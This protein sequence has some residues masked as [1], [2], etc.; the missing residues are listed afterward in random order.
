MVDNKKDFILN[1]Y[2]AQQAQERRNYQEAILFSQ[3]AAAAA[4]AGDDDWGF[5][6]MKFSIATLQYELGLL[7]ESVATSRQLVGSAAISAFPDLQSKAKVLLSRALQN[8]GG[9]EEALSV[10]RDASSDVEKDADDASFDARIS[11]QHGLVAALAEQGDLDA[12]WT[13]AMKLEEMVRSDASPRVAGMANWTIGNVGFMAGRN[14]EGLEYHKRASR[15]LASLNDVAQWGLFNKASAAVRLQAGVIESET[16]ECIERAEVA[17]GI[18]GAAESDLLELRLA[19]GRWE[20]EIGNLRAA[21]TLSRQVATDASMLYPF[22]KA[23][24]LQ[25]LALSL[26][27]AGQRDKAIEAGRDSERLFEEVGAAIM[28]AET[29]EFVDQWVPG[30]PDAEYGTPAE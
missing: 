1:E 18:T 15:D 28:A 13:E 30:E 24:A 6:R 4:S 12:A 27:A 7:D 8:Q 2:R 3:A 23:R 29:K 22:L 21:E 10:A 19:R 14:G 20:L 5:C 26:A 17:L 11:S 9:M 16:L 25:L